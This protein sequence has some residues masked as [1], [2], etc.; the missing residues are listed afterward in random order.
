MP[1][2]LMSFFILFGFEEDLNLTHKPGGGI[3]L[4]LHY[5]LVLLTH[6]G[7]LR[8]IEGGAT[9]AGGAEQRSPSWREHDQNAISVQGETGTVCHIPSAKNDSQGPVAEKE[10]EDVCS[11]AWGGCGLH[12]YQYPASGW[13]AILGERPD[14]PPSNQI[15]RLSPPYRASSASFVGHLHLQHPH[16]SIPLGP[17]SGHRT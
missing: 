17:I 15:S 9:T 10:A 4:Q 16:E 7:R 12:H 14:L 1:T 8:V 6:V 3:T 2:V 13:R 5:F 11:E